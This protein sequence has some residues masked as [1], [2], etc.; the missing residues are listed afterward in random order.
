MAHLV[1]CCFGW[2]FKTLLIG[3]IELWCFPRCWL[4]CTI[5]R[6][7][8]RER[9][10]CSRGWSHLYL[11]VAGGCGRPG[12]TVLRCHGSVTPGEL[13]RRCVHCGHSEAVNHLLGGFQ[14]S[15][16]NLKKKNSVPAVG[17]WGYFVFPFIVRLRNHIFCRSI[18]PL[19]LNQKTNCLP[20]KFRNG[21]C[22]D[23]E[24]WMTLWNC[25]K[26]YSPNEFLEKRRAG[27]RVWESVFGL[28][29]L[30]WYSLGQHNQ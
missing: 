8:R 23:V 1:S 9:L 21:L 20:T 27:G 25:W 28:V 15:L 22:W 6:K 18:F 14:G 26:C 30:C 3:N 29:W 16:T 5:S 4:S 17:R 24:K 12:E 13:R 10:D 11:G 19:W 2:V 7:R